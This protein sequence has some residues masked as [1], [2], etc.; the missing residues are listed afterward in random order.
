MKWIYRFLILIHHIQTNFI[1]SIDRPC[2]F[3]KVRIP[4]IVSSLCMFDLLNYQL[5]YH[6][7]IHFEFFLL[8]SKELCYDV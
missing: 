7:T 2:I 5:K 4:L 6:G 3:L 8:H 1:E